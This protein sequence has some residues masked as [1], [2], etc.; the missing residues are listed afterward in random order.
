MNRLGG[1]EEERS[2]QTPKLGAGGEGKRAPC[3]RIRENT[4][5]AAGNAE[6]RAKKRQNC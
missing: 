6:S 4:N 2:C 5:L 3:E 1:G